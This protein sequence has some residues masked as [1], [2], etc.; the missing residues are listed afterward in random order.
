[1]CR[2]RAHAHL[3]IGT[4]TQQLADCCSVSGGGGGREEVEKGRE[5]VEG[6]REEVGRGRRTG[7]RSKPVR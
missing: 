5:L 6:A 7:E 3:N 1:M 2:E 4:Q